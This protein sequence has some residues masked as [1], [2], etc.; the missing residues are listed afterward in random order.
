MSMTEVLSR[1]HHDLNWKPLSRNWAKFEIALGLIGFVGGLLIAQSPEMIRSANA[2]PVVIGGAVLSVLGGYLA[3]AGH[4]SHLYQS[5]SK[6]VA[7]IFW[8]W[9]RDADAFRDRPANI[10]EV[11]S[12]AT[13]H[14]DLT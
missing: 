5:N 4:R 8:R 6:L 12:N 11:G 1:L 3:L 13:D 7:Y 2:M 10:P 9:T 14:P